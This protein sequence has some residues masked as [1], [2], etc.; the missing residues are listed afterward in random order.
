MSSH[1]IYVANIMNFH[2]EQEQLPQ[3]V[4]GREQELYVESVE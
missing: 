3:Q 4:I 2:S 1:T